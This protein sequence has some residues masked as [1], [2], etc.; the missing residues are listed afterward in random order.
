MQVEYKPCHNL[1]E[2]RIEVQMVCF[3]TV[4]YICNKWMWRPLRYVKSQR[5]HF[6][7]MFVHVFPNFQLTHSYY[8]C[9]SGALQHH[10]VDSGV[11]T[12]LSKLSSE[13][14]VTSISDQIT[15]LI[16]MLDSGWT[17]TEFVSYSF[18]CSTVNMILYSFVISLYQCFQ[19][20]LIWELSFNDVLLI[21]DCFKTIFYVPKPRHIIS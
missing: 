8:F 19:H 9:F 12:A 21:W 17:C 14:N 6:E 18:I 5:T 2:T 4:D 11:S 1:H 7:N 13:E 10:L 15:R 20:L 3:A 16:S